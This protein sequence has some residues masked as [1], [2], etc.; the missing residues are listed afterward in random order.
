MFKDIGDTERGREQI[1]QTIAWMEDMDHY[2]KPYKGGGYLKLKSINFFT[3]E[4]SRI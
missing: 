2:S 4:I 3:V 1:I